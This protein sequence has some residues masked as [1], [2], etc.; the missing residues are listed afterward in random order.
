[1]K[2]LPTSLLEAA[3]QSQVQIVLTDGDPRDSLRTPKELLAYETRVRDTLEQLGPAHHP[4]QV[5]NLSD[6]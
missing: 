2:N 3:P 5:I 4:I 6:D 1:M